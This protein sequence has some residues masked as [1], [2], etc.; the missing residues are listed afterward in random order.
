MVSRSSRVAAGREVD[1]ALQ[2]AGDRRLDRRRAACAD[3]ATPPR[4]ARS[5]ARSPRPGLRPRAASARSSRLLDATATWPANAWSTSRSSSASKAAP[6]EHEHVVAV[7][8]HARRRRPRDGR[9]PARPTTASTAHPVAGRSPQHRDRLGVERAR[10]AAPTSSGSGS[11][12]RR[13]ACRSA[14]PGSRPRPGAV[15]P[16]RCAAAA[17]VDQHAH[18]PP[19]TTR[20]T[21]SASEV[22]ALRDRELVERRR[23]EPVGEQEAADRRD[24][25]GHEAAERGDDHDEQEEEQQDRSAASR[26]SRSSA[27]TSGEQR[28]RDDR[29]R[30]ADARRRGDS[31]ASAGAAHAT[32]SGAGA[33]LV[34]SSVEITWTSMV[35]DARITSLIT[36]PR[37]SSSSATA[38]WRRARSASRSRPGRTAPAPRPTS[39]PATSWYSP[40]SSSSSVPVLV[41][42]ARSTAPASPSVDRTCTPSSSPRV[43]VAMRAARRITSSPP[44]RPVIATTTRSRVS[45]GPAMPWASRY[46]SS[47][48]S[49]RSAT[50]MQRELA[51]RAEVAAPEVVGERGVD[52]LGRVDVA[53]RHAPAQRLGR[54]VDELD[55]LGRAARPRRGS[56]PA[57]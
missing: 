50:H 54:H 56:S 19:P 21:T 46:S 9:A 27:S 47:A 3:R 1:V 22:L 40:P 57:A 18:R 33:L 35:P 8:R 31:R 25:R 43:R 12:A 29:Q 6:D 42:R 48:S 55:L 38:G 26:C 24:E 49:T 11:S 4:A 10:G 13:R 45:H 5:A 37:M 44:G 17:D 36:E 34:A 30:P 41:E 15:P 23:E 2:Q 39:A 14:R 53:V 52:L 32:A 16:R 51:Q 7:E 20:N 28:R